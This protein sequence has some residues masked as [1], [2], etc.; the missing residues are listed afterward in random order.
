MAKKKKRKQRRTPYTGQ[1]RHHLLF[2]ARHWNVGRAKILRNAFVRMLD[3]RIHDEL[4]NR[5]LHDVPQPSAEAIT[6]VFNAFLANEQE[7]NQ[8]GIV[9]AAEWLQNACDEEPFHSAMERQAHFL[10]EKLRK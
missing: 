8:L 1:N 6:S 5:V 10:K 9:E 2:Q 4:H 3:V 7:I